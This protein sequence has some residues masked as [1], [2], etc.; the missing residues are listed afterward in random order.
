MTLL[1]NHIVISGS[2]VVTEIYDIRFY[3]DQ[4]CVF[5][6]MY[7]PDGIIGMKDAFWNFFSYLNYLTITVTDFNLN[8]LYLFDIFDM[9]LLKLEVLFIRLFCFSVRCSNDSA[10]I[11]TYFVTFF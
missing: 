11:L 10:R 8:F 9:F 1:W 4:V 6:E 5:I 2:Y 3:I 7:R